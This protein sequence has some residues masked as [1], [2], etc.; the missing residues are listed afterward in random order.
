M[1][2]FSDLKSN[3]FLEANWT[4]LISGL[5]AKDKNA[6]QKY[7]LYKVRLSIYMYIVYEFIHIATPVIEK[8]IN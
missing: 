1:S 4:H 7:S 8:A 5:S 6:L 3:F 2:F